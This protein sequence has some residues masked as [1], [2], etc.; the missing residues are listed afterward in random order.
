MEIHNF[1][2]L[3]CA[4]QGS[5]VLKQYAVTKNTQMNKRAMQTNPTGKVYCSPGPVYHHQ[6]SP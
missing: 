6:T 3:I 4:G 2:T 5:Q 1:C